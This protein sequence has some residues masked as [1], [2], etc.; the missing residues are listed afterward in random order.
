MK[1]FK[2]LIYQWTVDGGN[3][4]T[5]A[6]E[7]KYANAISGAV[8]AEERGLSNSNGIRLEFYKANGGY[9]IET[10]KY[11]RRKDENNVQLYLITEDQVLSDELSK[12][13]TMESLR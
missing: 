4:E 1:W 3:Y 12:I 9:V 2:K 11:D 8:V 5:E 6:R 7:K 13:I 10:R